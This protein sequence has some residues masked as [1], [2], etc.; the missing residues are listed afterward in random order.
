MDRCRGRARTALLGSGPGSCAEIGQLGAH[1]DGIGVAGVVQDGERL[2]PG[3]AGR[4]RLPGRVT[5]VADMAQ[6]L[7]VTPPVTDLAAQVEV[8]VGIGG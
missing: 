6:R 8:I 5:D 7:G 1:L 2:L 4:L 3:G